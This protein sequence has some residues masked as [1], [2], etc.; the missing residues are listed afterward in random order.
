M[1]LGITVSVVVIA[2]VLVVTVVGYLIN[3]V[4]HRDVSADR[5]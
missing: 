3:R 4:N 1:L 5:R 2:G